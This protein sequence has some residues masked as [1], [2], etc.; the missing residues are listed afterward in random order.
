[1]MLHLILPLLLIVLRGVQLLP[2]FVRNAG[3][4]LLMFRVSSDL[5]VSSA[6]IF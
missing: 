1:M 3:C 5:S 2:I 4:F 6:D